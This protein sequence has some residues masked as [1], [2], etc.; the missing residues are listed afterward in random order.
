MSEDFFFSDLLKQFRKRKRLNQTQLAEQIEVTRETVS[1]WERGQ[2]KPEADRILYKIGDMSLPR[3][4]RAS[5][6]LS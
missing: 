6:G 4:R 5:R 3:F 2:Y 1:L